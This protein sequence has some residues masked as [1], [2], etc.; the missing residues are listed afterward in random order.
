MTAKVTYFSDSFNGMSLA[1]RV[2]VFLAQNSYEVKDVSIQ[3]VHTQVQ[4]GH[5]D[6]FDNVQDT[7][8]AYVTHPA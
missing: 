4:T 7:F 5:G 3:F 6:C 8:E 2:S 1:N